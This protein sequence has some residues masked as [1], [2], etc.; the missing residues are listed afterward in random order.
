M[1][2]FEPVIPEDAPVPDE[3]MPPGV[4]KGETDVANQATPQGKSTD[5]AGEDQ[6]TGAGT[7]EA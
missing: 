4:E 1:G 7:E 2:A 6:G 5:G 3:R